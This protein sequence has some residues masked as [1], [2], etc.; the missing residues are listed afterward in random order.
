MNWDE[1]AEKAVAR[2]PFFAGK[3]VREKIE[4]EARRDGSSVVRTSH[5]ASA[6]EGFLKGLPKEAR[7]WRVE[8]CFGSS[9]CENRA[10]D[11]DGLI[12]ELEKSLAQAG[13][14]D[15]LREK[16]QGELKMHHEFQV[17]VSECPNC[18]SRPQIAD[19]GLIGARKPR[20]GPG[21]CTQCGS[22]VETCRE[23]ALGLAP[24]SS[25]PVLDETRCLFC[26]RCIDACPTGAL[27]EEM[28]GFRVLVGGKLGR[29]PQ[30][31]LEAPGLFSEKEVI[32]LLPLFLRHFRCNN[33]KGERW[34]E[35][36]KR[37]GF[38]SVLDLIPDRG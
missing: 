12:P 7:G 24:G 25:G 26:G 19:L 13:L 32:A 6:R 38:E 22:C 14:A 23:E 2:V 34:G 30:L 18:C 31:G 8:T 17:V 37:L 10:A 1:A 36:I 16:V 5:V 20:I 3:K 35:V 33:Q 21:P 28:V 11:S 15:F 4:A 29:R 27:E 9:G